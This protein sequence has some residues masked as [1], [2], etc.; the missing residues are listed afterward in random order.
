M[1]GSDA[2]TLPE[3][4]RA[5]LK[6]PDFNSADEL[7]EA[8]KSSSFE[9]ELSSSIVRLHSTIAKVVNKMRHQ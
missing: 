4:G 6:L 1:V 3:L 2:H 5:V 7:R 8:V 9:G